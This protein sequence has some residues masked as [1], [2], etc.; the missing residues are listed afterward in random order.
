[1]KTRVSAKFKAVLFGF[2]Y[3]LSAGFPALAD[4]TEIFFGNTTNSTKLPNVLFILDTSGSMKTEVGNTNKTRMQH[5]QQALNNI[6]TTAT[7]VNVGLMRFNDPG[8]PILFPVSNIS[9]ELT[10]ATP[11]ASGTTVNSRIM[12]SADDAEEQSGSMN[13]NSARLEAVYVGGDTG[14][15]A[16]PIGVG[17]DDVEETLSNSNVT[18]NGKRININNNQINGFRFAGSGIPQ[19]ASISSATLSLTART[20]SADAMT[21]RLFGEL[22]NDAVPFSTASGNVSGRPKT[23]SYIDWVP[24]AWSTDQVYTSPDISS[25]VQELVNQNGWLEDDLVLLQTFQSGSGERQAYTYDANDAKAAT[26]NVTYQMGTPGQQTIGL[27]FRDVGIPQGAQITSAVIEFTAAQS[28]DKPFITG[29]TIQGLDSDNTEAFSTSAS[30][31]T[32]RSG[33]AATVNWAPAAW[34]DGDVVQT[35]EIKTLVQEIV[36]RAGWCGNNAMGFRISGEDLV[37]RVAHSFD[38]NPDLAPVLR[39]TY[40]DSAL[41][42]DQGC[43]NQTLVY[44]VNAAENDAEERSNGNVSLGSNTFDMVEGQTNGLRFRNVMLKQGATILGASLTFTAQSN[45]TASTSITFAGQA[46]DNASGFVS[47]NGNISDRTTTG[48]VNWSPGD[49]VKNNRYE[50]PDLKAIIEAIVGRAGW[51]PGNDL[52]IIQTASSGGRY[53]YTY[54]N[55]PAD[56]AVLKIRVQNS[57][58]AL[59]AKKTVRTQLIEIVN[60]FRPSGYTPIVDTLYEAANYYRGGNVLYGKSRGAQTTYGRISHIDSY[61][62]G[63]VSRDA[64]CTDDNLNASACSSEQITGSPVYTSPIEDACQTNHIVLLTDGEAN[65]NNSISLVKSLTGKTSCTPGAGGEACGRELSKWLASTDQGSISGDQFVK[66]YTIGFNLDSGGQAGAIDFLQDLAREGDGNYY[67]AATDNELTLVFQNILRSILNTDTTFVSPGATVNQFNRLTHQNDIYFSVFKPEESPLWPGNLKR[68]EIKGNPAIIVDAN[69]NAAV[70]PATGFFATNSQSF[71][72]SQTDGNKV[73]VGGAAEQL[74]LSRNVYTYTGVSSDLTSDSNKVLETN[75][76]IDKTMLGIETE[77]DAHRTKLLEWARG[78]DRKDWD[79]DNN[80]DEIRHQ[81]GAP[82]HSQAVVMTY[83]GTSGAQE[84]VVFFGTNEGY[85]HAI[86]TSDGSEKFAFIPQELLP[87]LNTFFENADAVN[88]P[89]GLDGPITYWVN[90]VDGDHIIEA[91]DG[92][93]V[94]LYVGM[95]RGGRNYYALDVTDPDAPSLKWIIKGGSGDFLE[96]GQTWSSAVKTAVNI[97]GTVKQVLIFSGGYDTDQDDKIT[98]SADS[99]GR[100]LYIVDAES[101]ALLWSAGPST[102]PNGTYTQ[103]FTDMNYSIPADLRVIDINNDGFA[104]Q[105]YVG[106]MGGQLWRFDI[107]NGN[108]ATSLVSGGVIADLALNASGSNDAANNRRF[109]YAPD[110]SIM[111]KGTQKFLSLAVGSGWRAHPLNTAVQDRFYMVRLSDIYSV[112]TSYTK[113][114][115]SNLYDATDNTIGEG[116]ASEQATALSSLWDTY[117]GWYMD[118]PNSGEKVLAESLTVNN[119]I[120]FTS[121]EPVASGTSCSAGTGKGRLYIVSAYDATPVMNLDQTGLDSELTASDR[122]G[123]LARVGIPPKPTVLFPDD[124]TG[125]VVP[126]PVL[127]VGA[128]CGKDLD[129]GQIMERTFWREL[130]NN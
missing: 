31:I 59:P 8:G 103:S 19:G 11:S 64:A 29:L 94:Y 128:E 90:D 12:D 40:D 109:Y 7:G 115:H 56:A 57:G 117:K 34:T 65:H 50:T 68:Y 93:H 17:E 36:D 73:P 6:L 78:V 1:M 107:K 20:N 112:P 4:D 75:A 23:S 54:N 45:A 14:T 61:T 46:A 5:M 27:R 42:A 37:N 49:W 26:L 13:L 16:L 18:R 43:I 95:R 85:L 97:N 91:A 51:Q 123:E 22:S 66:T 28:T 25:I 63:T 100:A 122:S 120:L 77:T 3:T 48:S 60:E 129:F 89:Y 86:D 114:T 44:R 108:A 15:V 69:D 82:L 39:V 79:G 9:A 102:D 62:G 113:L 124:P 72:S 67:A 30:N 80:Y 130:T 53:A 33:T 118:L 24:D 106:D 58:V 104:D 52:A 84:N 105:M 116:T 127:C 88:L 41:T 32:G 21:L 125:K 38:G 111:R 83:G 126:D 101:G 2:C 35:P 121:F 55:Q 47:V 70:D 98:R 71:W 119:Q 10:T 99:Q 74:V 96:L 81:L 76:L 92:D 110:V 87:N